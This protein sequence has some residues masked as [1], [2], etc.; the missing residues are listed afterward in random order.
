MAPQAYLIAAALVRRADGAILLVREQGPDDPEAKW[1]LPGGVGE[2][3]ELLHEALAR[4]LREETGLE[5]RRLGP[6]ICVAQTHVERGLLRGDS[7]AEPQ[8]YIATAFTVEIAQWRGELPE[9]LA[10]PDGFVAEARFF[11]VPEALA[12]LDLLTFRPMREP[13]V[14]YLRGEVAPGALW[15]YRHAAEDADAQLLLRVP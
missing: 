8:E 10:D 5:L 12:L 9:R 7:G 13:I 11:A 1:A 14:A 3:G 4:E 2:P 15:L 6:L